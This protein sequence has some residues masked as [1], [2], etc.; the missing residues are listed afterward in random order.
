MVVWVCS[1]GFTDGLEI[2]KSVCDLESP[3]NDV[4]PGLV[5][6]AIS[7]GGGGNDV[8]HQKER[9]GVNASCCYPSYPRSAVH[10]AQWTL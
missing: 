6:D 4:L 5:A 7:W 1:G 10:T 8:P 9:K 2:A 3:P